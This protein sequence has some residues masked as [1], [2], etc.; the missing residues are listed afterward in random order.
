MTVLGLSTITNPAAGLAAGALDHDE[1]LKV[2][3][4]VRGDLMR[5]VRGIVRVSGM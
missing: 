3:E 5:L 2:S 4:R 1:V